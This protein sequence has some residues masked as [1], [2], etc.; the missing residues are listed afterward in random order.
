[1]TIFSGHSGVAMDIPAAVFKAECLK[2]MDEVAKTRQPVTI[3]KH[4]RPV[5][6][7]APVPAAPRSLFGY[8]KN[9]VKTQGDIVAPLGVD[10]SAV[11]GDEDRLH[12]AVPSK[13]TRKK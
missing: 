9:T 3:T 6:Q 11:S 2:L 5:A 1:M 10:W 4:G 13:R 7:L 12:E 8:M